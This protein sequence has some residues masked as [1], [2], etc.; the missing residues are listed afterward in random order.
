MC[1]LMEK[2]ETC[3]RGR[4]AESGSLTVLTVIMGKSAQKRSRK[5]ASQHEKELRLHHLVLDTN[6]EELSQK[7]IS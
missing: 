2:L 1:G 7:M 5:E 4:T 3:K 6:K